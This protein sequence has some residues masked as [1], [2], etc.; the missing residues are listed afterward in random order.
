MKKNMKRSICVVVLLLL[1]AL[2]VSCAE[3]EENIV[4]YTTDSNEKSND[5]SDLD[6]VTKIIKETTETISFDILGDTNDI[7]STDEEVDLIDNDNVDELFGNENVVETT[8]EVIEVPLNEAALEVA[9]NTENT[10]DM[11]PAPYI[12]P[13]VIKAQLT[14]DVKTGYWTYGKSPITWVYVRPNTKLVSNYRPN[15]SPNFSINSNATSGDKGCFLPILTGTE[16]ASEYYEGRF[17]VFGDSS[18]DPNSFRYINSL[19]DLVYKNVKVDEIL[20]KKYDIVKNTNGLLETN[21]TYINIVYVQE[22]DSI[23]NE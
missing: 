1:G 15:G 19:S 14:E 3:Y 18:H 2:L 6:K 12:D 4:L 16:N 23:I 22:L 21:G 17:F 11:T 8:K 10:L 20:R 5:I 9:K 7:I 13:A